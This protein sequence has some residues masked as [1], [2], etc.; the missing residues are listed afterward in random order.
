MAALTL[1]V[2][3]AQ[4]DSAGLT[5]LLA[6]QLPAYAM[7]LFLRLRDEH[8]IT[9]TFK[10]RKVELKSEGFDIGQIAEAVLFYAGSEQGYVT[11]DQTLLDSI[12]GG[13]V[14]L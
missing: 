5:R 1:K 11:L 9:G 3:L 14:R 6:R 10:N 7:P 13:K 4:F 12:R 2:P 8:E